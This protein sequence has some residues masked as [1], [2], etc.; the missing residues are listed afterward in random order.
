LEVEVKV[1]KTL[2]K[3]QNSCDGSHREWDE[4][5]SVCRAAHH[6]SMKPDGVM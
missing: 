1:E 6:S 4:I 3:V 5:K 2:V